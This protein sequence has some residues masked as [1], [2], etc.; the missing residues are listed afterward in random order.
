MRAGVKRLMTV[1]AAGAMAIALAAAPAA[2]A[3]PAPQADPSAVVDATPIA[4]PTDILGQ[5]E[6]ANDQLKE[7]G[8]TPFLWPTAAVNCSQVPGTPLGIV[9]AVAGAAAGPTTPGVGDIALP[10]PLDPTKP[11]DLNAVKGGEVFYGF[12]PAGI[13]DDSSNKS[14]MNVG[15][16]NV[17]T[18]QGGFVPMGSLT[19]T[20][21]APINAQI[22][23]LP[24]Q[25]FRDVARDALAPLEDAL[26]A[27]PQ[28]GARAA[29]VETG[30]GTVLSLVMG[31]VTHSGG[32]C[33][34]L[35]TV[36]IQDVA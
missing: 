9:P 28:A 1:G 16:F 2:Q 18:F 25:A 31:S 5:L 34:F 36:G 27:L 21:M 11:F 32:T 17:D 8:I 7:F 35:P 12:F 6:A 13:V 30:K 14:G 23:A 22:D 20:I 19:S 4:A 15:W 24:V 29:I 26:D 3:G 10:N 33:Y